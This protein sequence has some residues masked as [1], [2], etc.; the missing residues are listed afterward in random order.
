MARTS[1]HL[2]VVVYD[3]TFHDVGST[4][5]EH[6]RRRLLRLKVF[7]ISLRIWSVRS[8]HLLELID[9]EGVSADDWGLWINK[10]LLF[11]PS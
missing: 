11:H 9:F 7:G 8:K 2:A 6:T 1:E 10:Y 3:A 4:P 5:R